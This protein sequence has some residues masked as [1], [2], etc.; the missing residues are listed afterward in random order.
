MF[1]L[2]K[3]NFYEYL[4]LKIYK[5]LKIFS[6]YLLIWIHIYIIILLFVSYVTVKGGWLPKKSCEEMVI[7]IDIMGQ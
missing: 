2:I 7:K 5:V 6:K 1:Y 3:L 4:N